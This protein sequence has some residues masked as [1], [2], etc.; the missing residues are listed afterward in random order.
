M[1]EIIIYDA[2]VNSTHFKMSGNIGRNES[3]GFY[4]EQMLRR[5]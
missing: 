3:E 5:Y 1:E 4:K 2:E